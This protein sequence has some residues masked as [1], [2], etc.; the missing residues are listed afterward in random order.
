[1]KHSQWFI[2]WWP[3]RR[4]ARTH[5]EVGDG[6][7]LTQWHFGPLLISRLTNARAPQTPRNPE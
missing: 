7:F 4:I 5:K 3:E 1:M 6:L 2:D